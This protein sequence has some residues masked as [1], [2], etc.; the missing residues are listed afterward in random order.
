LLHAHESCTLIFL[1]VKLIMFMEPVASGFLFVE[2]VVR[3]FLFGKLVVCLI[4][5]SCNLYID[6]FLVKLILFMELVSCWFFVHGTC[7]VPTFV[8]ETCTL[9]YLLVEVFCSWNSLSPDFFFDHGTCQSWFLLMKLV[10]CWFFFLF[11][12]LM[13]LFFPRETNFF[14][15]N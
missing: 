3:W 9:V 10:A 8:R 2:L 11:V 1:L 5:S 15:L 4:F 13:Y 14:S 12:K 6:L 7:C